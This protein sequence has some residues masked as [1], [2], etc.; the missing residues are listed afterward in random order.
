MPCNWREGGHGPPP[1]RRRRRNADG[2]NSTLLSDDDVDDD[3]RTTRTTLRAMIPGDE[4][5]TTAVPFSESL[6][7][8]QSLQV[9]ANEEEEMAFKNKTS[10]GE[11]RAPFY[12][13]SVGE[14]RATRN[15]T[16]EGGYRALKKLSR[17]M[18]EYRLRRRV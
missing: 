9:L 11:S 1:V 5:D 16:P 3:V 13:I 14:S 8:F 6:S 17:W 7:L 4:E 12:I 18:Q 15:N 10:G 2:D